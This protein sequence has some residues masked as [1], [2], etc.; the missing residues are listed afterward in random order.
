M[1]GWNEAFLKVLDF[2][3]FSLNICHPFVFVLMIIGSVY[4]VLVF[5]VLFVMKIKEL[6]P[7]MPPY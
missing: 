7:I 5:F 1:V 3:N 6:L 4:L 2:L